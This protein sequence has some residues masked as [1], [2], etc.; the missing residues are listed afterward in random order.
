MNV[1]ALQKQPIVLAA[2]GTG[3]HVY[4]ALALA[5]VLRSRNWPIAF[6]TD[7]RGTA[8]GE[9]TPGTDIHHIKAAS[10]GGGACSKL[11]GL[12]QLGVGLLQA[13]ALLKRLSPAAAVGF[14]GYPSVPT[15]CAAT[16]MGTPTVIHEQNAVLGRVNRL[17]APR[18]RTIATSFEQIS[19]IQPQAVGKVT[20]T[21][22]PVRAAISQIGEMPY[23]AL[24]AVDPIHIL[25]FGGS[26]GARVL[27]E[28]VPTALT[29]LS[30]D[31]RSRLQVTQQCRSED[32]ERVKAAYDAADISASLATYFDNMPER[33][34]AAHLVIARAG[35]STISEL[36]AAGRPALLIP[37]P[38]ATDDHQTENANSV[39]AAGASWCI[40]EPEFTV[41]F[42]IDELRRFLQQPN[43]LKEA[44]TNTKSLRK[45][46]AAERLADAVEATLDLSKQGVAA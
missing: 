4:P 5:D 25:I 19:G 43:V 21:G 22:N 9:P 1:P 23:P 38:H 45:A 36:M 41:E 26:Q 18:V 35:A 8:F 13:R 7:E 17:L 28:I 15:M 27:S 37:Y 44:A 6:V 46:D 32:I 12:T 24:T 30:Q 33:L 40:P 14:G 29:S 11:K 10:L 39:A 31:E 3:G 42:V 20:L 16:Q 34:S 2:G